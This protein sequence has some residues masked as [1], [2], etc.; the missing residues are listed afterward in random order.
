M[1]QGTLEGA[2]STTFRLEVQLCE[3]PEPAIITSGAVVGQSNN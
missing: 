2:E 3:E 1:L